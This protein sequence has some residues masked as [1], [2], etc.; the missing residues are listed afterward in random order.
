MAL[1]FSASFRQNL[2]K[3]PLFRSAEL[4]LVYNNVTS[5]IGE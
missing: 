2:A 4:T 1:V 5:S 3:R